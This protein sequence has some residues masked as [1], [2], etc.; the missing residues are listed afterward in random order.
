[1]VALYSLTWAKNDISGNPRMKVYV[2]ELEQL[3]LSINDLKAL[4]CYNFR[5]SDHGRYVSFNVQYCYTD[6]VLFALISR[7]ILNHGA[8]L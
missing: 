6:P 2:Y 5:Y 8:L 1:M 7:N 4:R 3:G